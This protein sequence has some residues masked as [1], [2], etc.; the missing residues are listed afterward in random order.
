MSLKT[1]EMRFQPR[2]PGSGGEMDDRFRGVKADFDRLTIRFRGGEISRR[3]YIESLKRMRFKDDDGRFWMIGSQTGKWYCHDADG[4]VQSSP[5]SLSEKKAICI[6]CGY[7]NDL[8][9]AACAGCGGRVAS[10]DAD[11]CPGCGSPLDPE[12]GDCLSCPAPAPPEPGG[13]AEAVLSRTGAGRDYIVRSIHPLS[14]LLFWGGMGLVAGV[15]SG[16]L[17]GATS[18][19]PGVS[20][21]LPA[22]FKDMQGNFLGGMIYAGLGGVAGFALFGAAGFLLALLANAIL[23]ITGGVK[24]RMTGPP[25]KGPEA[26]D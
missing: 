13:P 6:Y 21:A 11:V 1:N 20:D 3:E 12:T 5:P 23:S 8:E 16:L 2:E 4:W 19:V 14:Y 9:S 24:M 10:A 7:E 15:L 17:A 18:F 22:F 26:L 25:G